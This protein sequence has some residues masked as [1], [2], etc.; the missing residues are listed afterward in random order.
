MMTKFALLGC[1]AIAMMAMPARAQD[2]MHEPPPP[3][4]KKIS[5]VTKQPSFLPGIGALY[6]DPK[7]LPVGPYLAYDHDGNRVSTIFMVPMTIFNEQKALDGLT[8][9]SVKVDHVSIYYNV[10]HSGAPEPHYHIVL[11]NVP[12]TEEARVAK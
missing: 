1:A 3:P 2:A 8:V 6:V 7:T 12:V 5:E 11:W 9:P 4:F 10:G